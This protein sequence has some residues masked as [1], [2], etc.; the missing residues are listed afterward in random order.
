MNETL[1]NDD[2]DG[3]QEEED[4]VSTP[5]SSSYE[6]FPARESAKWNNVNMILRWAEARY[7]EKNTYVCVGNTHGRHTRCRVSK[8]GGEKGEI[9]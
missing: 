9:Q 7:N 6:Y 3:E 8:G 5:T 1:R 4:Y 2:D